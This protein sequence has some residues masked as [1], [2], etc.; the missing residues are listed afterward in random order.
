MNHLTTK[1]FKETIYDFEKD[2]NFKYLGNQP[3]IILCSADWCGPCRTIAPVLE[4]LEKEGNFTLYKVDVDEE[5][6]LS[7]L[8]NIRSIPTILFVPLKGDPTSHTGSLPKSELK[9]LVVK[10][11]GE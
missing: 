8:F 4:D 5:Y 1:E 11:F 9:K 10:Y 7:E 3:C 2:K 6:E